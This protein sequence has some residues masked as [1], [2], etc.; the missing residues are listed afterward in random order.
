M[1]IAQLAQCLT[2]NGAPQAG[3]C[4]QIEADCLRGGGS[5]EMC[6]TQADACFEMGE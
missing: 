5:E 6:G 1:C 3:R 2:D 4:V